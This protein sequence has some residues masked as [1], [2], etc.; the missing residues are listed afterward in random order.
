MLALFV[1]VALSSELDEL[2]IRVGAAP[3][4]VREF[5]I[6]RAE[7]NHFMGEEAYDRARAR[8]LQK[9][10]RKLRCGELSADEKRIRRRFATQQMIGELLKC[11]K[12]MVGWD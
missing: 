2:K 4:P 5:I 9:A 3:R 1:A 6:R 10:V 8:E 7:C 11:T 12:D